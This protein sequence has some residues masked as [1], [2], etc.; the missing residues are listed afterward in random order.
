MKEESCFFCLRGGRAKL[1]LSRG[2]PRRTS[3][4]RYPLK[5]SLSCAA[6][7][8]RQKC[9]TRKFKILF[10]RREMTQNNPSENL[11]GDV[12]G[13]GQPGSPGSGGASPYLRRDFGPQR[14]TLNTY[15]SSN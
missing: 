10:A 8:V 3:L 5:A 2:F 9:V 12:L 14:T 7:A 13:R 11:G 15:I 1:R 6:I 4:R